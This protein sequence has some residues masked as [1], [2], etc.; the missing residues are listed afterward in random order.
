MVWDGTQWLTG[1]EGPSG[2]GIQSFSYNAGTDTLTITYDNPG[3]TA[4]TDE[5]IGAQN[6]DFGAYRIHY[7]NNYASFADLPSATTYPGMFVLVG[8]TPY[9]SKNG[10]WHALTFTATAA[11]SN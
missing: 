5:R 3:T 9:F 11:H 4:V 6:L 2:G 1:L 8:S 7:S 10:G